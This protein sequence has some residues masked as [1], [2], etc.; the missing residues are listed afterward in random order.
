MWLY[1]NVKGFKDLAEVEN[2][3]NHMI[4]ANY[5]K[6]ASN[7][8]LSG[9]DNPEFKRRENYIVNTRPASP[10]ND[11]PLCRTCTS[12]RCNIAAYG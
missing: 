11:S 7:Y 6:P 3:A 5:L 2:Y 4:S 10:G 9:E 8:L 12:Y 1:R